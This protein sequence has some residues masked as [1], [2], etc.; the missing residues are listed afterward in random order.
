M[1]PPPDWGDCAP[2]LSWWSLLVTGT[3]TSHV[4]VGTAHYHQ[5]QSN[6]H[7]VWC[8]QAV[9]VLHTF[10]GAQL[11]HETETGYMHSIQIAA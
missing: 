6:K 10:F 1:Y 3:H 8:S 11:P 4:L 7:Q 9:Q 2:L 5:Y